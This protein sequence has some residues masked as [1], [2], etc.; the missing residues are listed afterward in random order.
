MR[1]LPVLLLL[2]LLGCG[3]ATVVQ[4]PGPG[5]RE[6][7]W[8]RLEDSPLSPRLGPV[9]GYVD[10]R[11]VF[12]GGD[13]GAPCPPGADCSAGPE[14]AVDGAAYDVEKKTWTPIADAPVGIPDQAPHAVVG[15]H[16][17]VRV[18]G[19]LL[20]YDDGHDAWTTLKIPGAA[21]DWFSLTV[22]AGRLVLTSA[23]D[24]E[25]KQPDRVLDTRTRKWT[26]L[27]EDPLG[28]SFDRAIT[29]T[30]RGLVLTAH[31]MDSS[32]HPDDPALE[33]A[34]LLPRGADTWT[35]LPASDE[36]GGGRWTWTG[37][38]MVDP[39]PGG[40]DGGETNGYGRTIPNGGVLDPGSGTWSRLP[41]PPSEDSRGWPVDAS[42]G[43]VIAAGGWLYD[44]DA[45][46]WTTL[47]RPPDGPSS[48]G[49][50]VW[51]GA[52]LLVLGG[53]DRGAADESDKYTAERLYS[54]GFWAH[55]PA[56]PNY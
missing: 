11:A 21:P 38:R 33:R 44:D 43:E 39:T 46:T 18:E 53:A 8:V 56:R 55:L 3:Q 6:D 41:N 24:E 31:R 52:T 12:V 35:R 1:A 36:L 45:H 22:D 29:A 15:R 51:A 50:A 13:T 14:Y 30:D 2:T 54:T 48:P 47:T 49:S 28:P 20:D 4:S 32:G 34:A 37:S 42:H 40:S 26:A 23:S 16:L 17:F 19:Q 5:Q 10:G 9:S 25:V 27:P 7:T